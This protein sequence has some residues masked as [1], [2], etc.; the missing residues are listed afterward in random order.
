[1]VAAAEYL[2]VSKVAPPDGVAIYGYSTGGLMVGAVVNQRPDLFAAAL[3][4]VGVMDML[5]FDKFTDGALWVREYGSPEREADF[6]NLL[7]YSPYHNVR[8][9]KPYWRSW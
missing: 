6:R 3:P 1:M 7:S 5:R 9:G 8:A 2:R 4:S